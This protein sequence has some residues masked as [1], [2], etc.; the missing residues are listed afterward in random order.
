MKI[1]TKYKERNKLCVFFTMSQKNIL[2]LFDVIK[3]NV[4]FLCSDP[5]RIADPSF[6]SRLRHLSRP[7]GLGSR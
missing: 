4:V 2:I 3:L 7:W 5:E 6:A 1:F